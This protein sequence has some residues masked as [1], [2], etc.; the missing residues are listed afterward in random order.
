M[1]PNKNKRKKRTKRLPNKSLLGKKSLGVSVTPETYENLEDKNKTK[2]IE[3][4]IYNFLKEI[5]YKTIDKIDLDKE[6]HIYGDRIK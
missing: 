3:V 5:D 2:Y 6:N 1:N 4:I